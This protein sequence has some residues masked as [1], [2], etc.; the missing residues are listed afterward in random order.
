MGFKSLHYNQSGT[1]RLMRPGPAHPGNQNFG[2][3]W[4]GPRESGRADFCSWAAPGRAE[5]L[6][7]RAGGDP[8][9]PGPSDLDFRA[10]ATS[11]R[12]VSLSACILFY[13]L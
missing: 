9:G 5:K 12:P 7:A 2:L 3:V 8:S 6:T 13:S 4:A 10:T 11:F 1:A